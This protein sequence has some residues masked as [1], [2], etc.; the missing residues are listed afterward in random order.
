MSKDRF[1]ETME[2]LKKKHES[3]DSTTSTQEIFQSVQQATDKRKKRTLFPVIAASIIALLAGGIFFSSVFFTDEAGNEQEPQEVGTP[4]DS[5]EDTEDEAMEE[6]TETTEEP[7]DDSNEEEETASEEE[8]VADDEQ[9]SEEE[10]E[11]E[12]TEN[13]AYLNRE[14]TIS[15]TVYPEGMEESIPM[16]LVVNEEMGYSSYV[17]EPMIHREQNENGKSVDYYYVNF[18][19]EEEIP[20]EDYYIRIEKFEGSTVDEVVQERERQILE[21]GFT[22]REVEG[23]VLGPISDSLYTTEEL[24]HNLMIV[25]SDEAL[26]A[27]DTQMMVVMGDGSFPWIIKSFVENMQFAE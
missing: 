21:N 16:K 13:Q 2:N 19:E 5:E 11:E 15:E 6:D 20:S 10:A 8:E 17:H 18:T 27:I 23:Y 3:V 12:S 26:F 4:G 25:E 9:T 1:D 14:E 22:E 24:T 7:S